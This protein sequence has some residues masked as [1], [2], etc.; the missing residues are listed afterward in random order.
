ML[1]NRTTIEM[2]YDYMKKHNTTWNYGEFQKKDY[3]EHPR[4]TVFSQAQ[5]CRPFSLGKLYEYLAPPYFQAPAFENGTMIDLSI[6]FLELIEIQR[7]LGTENDKPK[8][9]AE[10]WAGG[11]STTATPGHWQSISLN[12]IRRRCYDNDDALKLLFAVSAATY[13]AGIAAWQNKRLYNSVRPVIYIPT[14][15]M[16]RTF[17]NQYVGMYCSFQDIEGWQWTPYQEDHVMTPEFQEYISGHSTFSR[18]ASYVLEKFTG[19]PNVPGNLSATIKAGQSLF[20]P[21]CNQSSSCYKKCRSNTLQDSE[22]NYIPKVDVTL[23]PWKTYRDIADE[24][25]MSRIYGGIHVRSGDIQGRLVG[26][27]VGETVWLKVSAL[28]NDTMPP[29][30]NN[31]KRLDFQ[32]LVYIIALFSYSFYY[33][34]EKNI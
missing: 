21:R 18:A 32:A 5:E 33:L 15:F 11:P 22:N 20:Q 7:T 17:S 31:G 12:I 23:G 19:S 30:G 3:I 8:L 34:Y 16:N 13:D 4:T 27:K 14:Q 29:S 25:S 6:Q 28:F 1:D 10:F 26:Q 2:C 9:I 24:A